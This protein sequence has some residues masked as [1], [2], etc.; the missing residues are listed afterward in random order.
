MSLDWSPWTI[1]RDPF[2]TTPGAPI[3]AVPWGMGGRFALFV[4]DP[5]G[6]VY[7][8]GGDPF[9]RWWQ[10]WTSVSEGRTTPG[11]PITVVP[12]GAGFALFIADPN[13]GVY[14]TVGNPN[15][16]FGPWRIVSDPFRTTPGAPLTA[17]VSTTGAPF[18]TLFTTARDGTIWTTTGDPQGD[19]G[20]WTQVGGIR[21]TAGSPV[22]ADWEIGW[23]FRLYVTD[24][25][26][27]I[28]TTVGNPQA[29]QPWSPVPGIAVPPRSPVTKLG[30]FLFV[31]HFTGE[32]VMIAGGGWVSVSQ[33]SAPPGSPVTACA[34]ANT[35]ALIALF[36]AD[37]NGGV[38][39]T[40]APT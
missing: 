20:Q 28:S 25:N 7:T 10:P 3:T 18:T 33:G 11:A 2:R 5:N 8:S 30:D 35:R 15:A 26:G 34:H 24:S 16:P 4:T 12:W 39:W 40:T 13:G 31:T 23:P 6:G 29:W 37:P 32:V 19:F 9:R 21:V 1:V 17:L 38:Y 36:I 22:T 27:G 14:T